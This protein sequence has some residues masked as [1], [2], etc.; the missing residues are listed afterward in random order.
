[1]KDS[2]QTLGARSP[3]Y[4]TYEKRMDESLPGQE[5]QERGPGEAVEAGVG[6]KGGGRR[7]ASGEMDHPKEEGPAISRGRRTDTWFKPNPK[8]KERH[9]NKMKKANGNDRGLEKSCTHCQCPCIIP[10]G[11]D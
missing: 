8:D 1:M 6:E 3:C 4:K 7:Q 2:M 5:A 10:Q 11:R 9:K